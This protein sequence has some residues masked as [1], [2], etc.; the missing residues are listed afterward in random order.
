MQP[1]ARSRSPKSMKRLLVALCALLS[2]GS[3]SLA[4]SPERV[5]RGNKVV[6]QADPAI[7]ITLPRS[8]RY[9]GADRWDLYDICDAEVHVFV[10]ADADRNVKALYWIQFEQYL[11]NNTHIYNYTQ[12]EP[13]TFGGRAF[14][15]QARFGASDQPPRAGSD[16][17]H[18]Q[19]IVRRAGY[20]WPA[21]TMNLRLV[22]LP[23]AS[24]RKELMF[25]YLEDLASTG[26][27]SDGLLDGEQPRPEW[28]A[29]Q[30]GLVERAAQRIKLS[31]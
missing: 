3:A 14:W 13:V 21:H 25:I 28:Q 4:A 19:A 16:L 20:R 15:R 10:E 6:S 7:T 17:E 18:V 30:Q 29:I 1:I 24:N 8:A 5:V 2:I 9:L 11:P 31:R 23:D 22:H 27:T 26:Y 12:D